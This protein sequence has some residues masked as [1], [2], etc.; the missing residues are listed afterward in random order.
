M[1]EENRPS[2]GLETSIKMLRQELHLNGREL[3]FRVTIWFITL[4]EE[5]VVEEIDGKEKSLKLKIVNLL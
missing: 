1:G 4:R 5:R 2:M 3:H